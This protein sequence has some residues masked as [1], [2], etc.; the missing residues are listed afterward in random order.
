MPRFSSLDVVLILR[1]S[2]S[3]RPLLKGTPFSAPSEWQGAAGGD[4]PRFRTC[5]PTRSAFTIAFAKGLRS[6]ACGVETCW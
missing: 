5:I 1:R 3:I 6:P 4:A 2:T